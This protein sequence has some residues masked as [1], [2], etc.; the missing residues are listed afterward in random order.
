M[1]SAEILQLIADLEERT[2]ESQRRILTRG[3]VFPADKADELV[4]D[5]WG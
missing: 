3:E 5:A 2:K 1:E 4:R